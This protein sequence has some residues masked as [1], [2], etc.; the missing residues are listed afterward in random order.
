[1]EEDFY[2]W[3]LLREL[4]KLSGEFQEAR[5]IGEVL[6]RYQLGLSDCWLALRIEDMISR[7]TLEA[8]TSPPADGP[9]YHRVLRIL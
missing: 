7:G 1:M 4:D 8:V 5:L 2:D 6:G 9:N 3:L